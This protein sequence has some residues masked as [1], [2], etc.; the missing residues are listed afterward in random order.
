[1][2]WRQVKDTDPKFVAH[3]VKDVPNFQRK[4]VPFVVHGDSGIYTTHE[5]SLTCVQWSPLQANLATWFSVFLITCFAK[6]AEAK[7]QDDGV[8]TWKVL[9]SY[10]RWSLTAL[11]EGV[12]PRFDRMGVPLDPM[13]DQDIRMLGG[14]LLANGEYIGAYALAAAD[15]EYLCK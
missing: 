3:P 5:D 12:F 10:V 9:W 2:V 7:E 13:V 1:M 15:M 8:D 11:C 6:S 14:E 4:A